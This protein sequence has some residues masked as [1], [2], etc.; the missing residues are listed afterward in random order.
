IVYT[1]FL[2]MS[3]VIENKIDI[4]FENKEIKCECIR[5]WRKGYQIEGKRVFSG[6]QRRQHREYEDC[7][8]GDGVKMGSK[9]P[10]FVGATKNGRTSNC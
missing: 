9:T 1:C 10:D 2:K 7:C 4:Y 5:I 6:L 3:I 8:S